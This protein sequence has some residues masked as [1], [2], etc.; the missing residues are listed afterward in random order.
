VVVGLW[1]VVGDWFDGGFVGWFLYK[2]F[3]VQKSLE[4][5]EISNGLMVFTIVLSGLKDCGLVLK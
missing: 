5:T 2:I 3:A 4:V 1:F